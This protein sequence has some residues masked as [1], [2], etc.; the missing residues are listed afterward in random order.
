MRVAR[1]K[2]LEVS[3]IMAVSKNPDQLVEVSAE[4]S[5]EVSTE[6]SAEV[7]TEVSAETSAEVS[8]RIIVL[9]N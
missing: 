8:A 4:V 3:R 6:V 1:I 2:L 5:A 9:R 7:S